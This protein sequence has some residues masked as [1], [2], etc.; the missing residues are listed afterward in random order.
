MNPLG[1]IFSQLKFMEECP[2]GIIENWYLANGNP[3]EKGFFVECGAGNG[4]VQTQTSK[5]EMEGW[6]GL[7]IESHDLLFDE[8]RWNRPNIK[9][10]HE[11]IGRSH[12]WVHFNE[13]VY[14]GTVNSEYL[15]NSRIGYGP[16]SK[17]KVSKSL[18][19]VLRENDCPKV[20]DY[21]VIDVEDG[22]EDAM[23][24]FDFGGFDVRFLA[25]EIKQSQKDKLLP[26]ILAQGYELKHYIPAGP[27]Y[28]FCKHA[29][30]KSPEV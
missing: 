28:L 24:N 18:T 25:V 1:P 19:E 9:C 12:H 5:L 16:F 20:I 13:V 6:S 23:M 8:L 4:L 7:L 3:P 11:T 21:M 26:H 22:A 29:L 2:V 10:I 14:D 15:G 30:S 27:D 17:L